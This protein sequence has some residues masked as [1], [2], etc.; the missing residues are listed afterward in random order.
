MSEHPSVCRWVA[1]CLILG[2]STLAPAA[3]TSRPTATGMLASLADYHDGHRT[4]NDVLRVV[5]FH[6]AD[7]SP[8]EDYEARIDRI[9]KDIQCFVRDGME[10]NG[11]G[12]MTFRLETREGRL[13]VHTVRGRELAEAY[14]YRKLKTAAGRKARREVAAALA[15][16]FDLERSFSIVFHG[17]VVRDEKGTYEFSAPYYGAGGSNQRFGLCHAADCDK[18]DT[19]LLDRAHVKTFF[20][21]REHTGS[22][23]Q[24]LADFNSKYI[25]GVAHE[26]GHAL[27]LPHNGETAVERK[28]LG[29]A[30]MGSGNHTYRRER[31][32]DRAGTFLTQASAVRLASHPLFSG[33]NRG[34]FEGTMSR[35][36]DVI[37]TRDGMELLVEGRVE[38]RVPA[39]AVV[40]YADPPGRSDY[41]ARTSVGVVHEGRFSLRLPCARG[42]EQSF[43]L[44]ICHVN[45]AVRDVEKYPLRVGWTGPDA[46]S[47]STRSIIG[48]CEGMYLAGQVDDALARA[49]RLLA[50]D[51]TP[52]AARPQ[53][54]HLVALSEAPAAPIVP[55]KTQAGELYLSDAAW[56]SAT[57][58]WGKPARNQYYHD[59]R[60][61]DSLFLDVGGVFHPK[62]LYAHSPSRYLFEL[63][64]SWKTFSAVGGLQAGVPEIGRAVFVVKADDRELYRSKVLQGGAVEEIK[65]SVKG[66]HRLELIVESGKDDNAYCWS[67]WGSPRVSR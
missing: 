1:F 55:G 14:D 27:G 12:P 56:T 33:S 11:F 17:L 62:G 13:V 18:L 2:I 47:L 7:L 64:G 49:R 34:R 38:G 63:D 59:D 6:P 10:R 41:D 60:V 61:R 29:A 23:R 20:R 21:Y 57:V 39:Y 35:V 28:S 24:T 66:V 50:D 8:Q 37:Y 15:D 53:L 4:S 58:G 43:R 3:P 30:L 52:K 26:L 42:A 22:F 44:A 19:R 16:R 54:Q 32:S 36:S 31:W 40:A 5:Y 46:Q 9:M 25:G 67:V 48:S 51:S 45:G 65:L